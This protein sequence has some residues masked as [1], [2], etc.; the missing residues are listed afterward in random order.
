MDDSDDYVFDDIVLDAQALALLDQEEQ[1]YLQR[2]DTAS[3][4]LI[5][6]PIAPEGHVNKRH[7]TSTGWAPG[8]GANVSSDNAYDDLPEISLRGDGT[9]GI[10]GRMSGQVTRGQILDNGNRQDGPV[11]VNTSN[12]RGSNAHASGSRLNASRQSNVQQ[13]RPLPSEN[14]FQGQSNYVPSNQDINRIHVQMVELQKKYDEMREENSKMQMTLKAA[15]DVKLAKEGEVSILRRNIEKASQNHAAQLSQ[16]RAEKEKVEQKQFQ[17]QKELKDELERLRSQMVF[18]QQELDSSMRKVPGSVRAKKVTR[19]IPSTPLQV[20]A[21]MNIWHGGASQVQGSKKIDETPIRAPRFAVTSKFSPSKQSRRPPEKGRN[22]PG[23]QNAFETSTPIFSPSKKM[24]KGKGKAEDDFAIFGN[25]DLPNIFPSQPMFGSTN[26]TPRPKLKTTDSQVLKQDVDRI[27]LFMG[28]DKYAF[29]QTTNRYMDAAP[30]DSDEDALMDVA[31]NFEAV[32]WKSELCRIILTHCHP[33]SEMSTFQQILGFTERTKNPGDYAAS[34]SRILEVISN[35]KSLR[36]SQQL[37]YLAILMN[38]M[39]RLV[40][41][42]PMFHSVLLSSHISSSGDEI[43]IVNLISRV[44]LENLEPTKNHLNKDQIATETISLLQLLCF[45]ADPEFINGIQSFVQNNTALLL[46][47]HTAQPNWL[48]EKSALVLVLLSTHHTLL[49]AILGMSPS[50]DKKPTDGDSI[51]NSFIDKLCSLLVDTNRPPTENFKIYILM[52]LAQI[53]VAHP[54]THSILVGSNVLI[55]SL[56]LYI[57]HLCI[58]LFE[59]SEQLVTSTEATS[60][61]VKALNQ[62]IFLLYHL[63][64]GHDPFLDLRQKLQ[65]APHRAFNNINDIFIVSFG[66][67]AYCDS[68]NW[69]EPDTRQEVEY[70]VDI[71]RD[72]FEVMVEGPEGESVWAAFQLEPDDAMDE[73]QMEASL[74]GGNG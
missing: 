14:R 4:N 57:S 2:P 11:Q 6:I 36:E 5:A 1:K 40:L 25:E 70:L 73:E 19:D 48:L 15:I 60:S 17:V 38:L 28:S 46:M 54:T 65:Q 13:K 47:L 27:P 55:P 24:D 33:S 42:I 23:F 58:P 35:S 52:F 39:H 66:R 49:T 53:L 72:I 63:I 21:S 16:L 22:L 12:S 3:Q 8:I 9:Y 59:E 44:I 18:K 69:M 30:T 10:G 62:A 56:V 37:H 64:F 50:T 41:S 34:C 74:I 45:Q 26:H 67:L 29:S 68:F 7:K 20:T 43:T 32:N 31:E 71:S 51:K 61:Y